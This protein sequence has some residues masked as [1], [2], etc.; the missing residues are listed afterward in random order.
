MTEI[1][2]PPSSPIKLLQS[3]QVLTIN[4]KSYQFLLSKTYLAGFFTTLPPA[5]LNRICLKSTII[6]YPEPKIVFEVDKQTNQLF[7]VYSGTMV[8]H[9]PKNR[10]NLRR[11]APKRPESHIDG[12]EIFLTIHADQVEGDLNI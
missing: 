3:I 1:P 11:Y 10:T 8:L 6:T 9:K 12:S 5:T 4:R 2:P 7:F